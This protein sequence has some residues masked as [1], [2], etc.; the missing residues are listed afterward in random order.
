MKKLS[1][2]FVLLFLTSLLVSCSKEEGCT[3]PKS[4]N[5]NPDAEKSDG[6]CQYQ[7]KI[8]FWN[9]KVFSDSVT[10]YGV[11][12]LKYYVDGKLL[13]ST[14]ATTFRNTAPTCETENVVTSTQTL[15]SSTSKSVTYEVK[16]QSGNTIATGTETV[17]GNGCKMVQLTW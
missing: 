11:T 1:F 2:I 13:T 12:T 5:Y 15:G 9:D 8:S 14:A 7:G 4:T 3:D 6:S 10:Y 16:D 17:E